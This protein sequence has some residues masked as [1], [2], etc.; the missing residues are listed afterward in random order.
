MKKSVFFSK[1]F[2]LENELIGILTGDNNTYVP[3]T[4]KKQNM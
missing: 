1:F 2:F 4:C 3:H